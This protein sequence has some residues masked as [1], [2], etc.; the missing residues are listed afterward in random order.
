[1][2]RGVRLDGKPT[3][4]KIESDEEIELSSILIASRVCFP[5]NDAVTARSLLILQSLHSLHSSSS[6]LRAEPI[7][8]HIESSEEMKES[9]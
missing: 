1:M 9:S 5:S 4:F 2:R 6:T 8:S 7:L 3:L